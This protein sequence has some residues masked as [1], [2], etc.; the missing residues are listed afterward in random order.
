MDFADSIDKVGHMP[1]LS[2]HVLGRAL[3]EKNPRRGKRSTG[4]S[5]EQ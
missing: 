4:A 3:V 1:R 2:S 5:S